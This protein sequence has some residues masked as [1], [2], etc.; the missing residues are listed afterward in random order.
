MLETEIRN[1]GLTERPTMKLSEDPNRKKKL[2]LLPTY[3][4]PHLVY[5][6]SLISHGSVAGT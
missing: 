5:L 2:L 6:F 4:S 1:L 3:L